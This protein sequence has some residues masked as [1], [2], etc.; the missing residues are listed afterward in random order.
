MTENAANGYATATL[1][2]GCFWCLEA[3]YLDL[4]GVASVTSGYTGGL[5]PDPSYEQVCTGTTGH[6]EAVQVRF[7][8]RVIGY[9][10]LLQVFF[11]IH[12]P[13]TRDRQGN[14]VGPQYRSAVFYHDDAQRAEAETVMREVERAGLYP[15]PLVT[16]LRAAGPFYPAEAYHRD[17]YANHPGEGY[18]RLIIAPKLAK[19]RKQH[20]GRLKG[21][22]TAG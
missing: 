17:Y 15:A 7:D 1:A 2:G 14:D 19:F 3:V 5:V 16:E 11:A 20:L 10:D 4:A 21:S 22:A 13:T 12:D 6:A 8:P 18:C 9:R